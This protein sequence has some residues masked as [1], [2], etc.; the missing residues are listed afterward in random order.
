MSWII[1]IVFM[2]FIVVSGIRREQRAGLWSW[3]K[4]AFTLGFAAVACALLLSPLFFL[5]LSSP[6]FWPAFSAAWVVVAALFVWF[7]IKCRSWKLPDGRTSLE[8][9]RD[10]QRQGQ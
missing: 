5:S 10:D 7:I 1:S 9:Y 6:Y 2:A 4:F 3:S 8:A